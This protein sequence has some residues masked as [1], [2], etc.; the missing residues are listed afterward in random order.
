M[1]CGGGV[2]IFRLLDAI[3]GWDADDA[4]GLTGLD[5]NEGITL[6]PT[7]PGAVGSG[8]VDPYLPPPWLAPGALRPARRLAA[9][10]ARGVRRLRLAGGLG[11]TLH[12]APERRHHGDRGIGTS[13]RGCG[14]RQ[15]GHPSVRG[16]GRS[17]RGADPA[18][19]RGGHDVHA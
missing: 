1:T 7:D 9:A 14:S 8:A 10:A 15:R 4:K 16:V 6:A 3:V 13:Y 17:P 11:R 12:R 18:H 19:W 2:S 5:D